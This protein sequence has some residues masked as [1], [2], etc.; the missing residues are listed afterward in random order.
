M[1]P[2]AG[3]RRIVARFQKSAGAIGAADEE[4]DGRRHERAAFERF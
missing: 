3:S 1:R 2:P 4:D